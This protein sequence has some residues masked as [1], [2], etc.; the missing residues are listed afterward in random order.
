VRY[1]LALERYDMT[2]GG[3]IRRA[4]RSTSARFAAL[5]RGLHDPALSLAVLSAVMSGLALLFAYL[6]GRDLAGE[7][8]GGLAAGIL[9]TSPLFWFFGGWGCR[10]RG[11]RRCRCWWRGWRERRARRGIAGAF[12]VMTIV[13]ALAFGFRSTFA[14]LVL[15]LWIYAVRRHSW[16]RIAA[17]AAV[18][19][20][21]RVRLT[22]LVA[23]KSGGW[24]AYRAT[25]LGASSRRSSWR[26]RSSAAGSGR[27]R[28]RRAGSRRARSWGWDSSWC[29]SW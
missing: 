17:G 29:R 23:S 14:V 4:I 7:A 24:A 10:R 9:A 3:R 1:A 13:L 28:H 16:M 20:A 22:A 18:L 21:G 19:G 12:W 25:D 6:L 2:A 5:D 8:A 15:P 26:R 27:S 11:R